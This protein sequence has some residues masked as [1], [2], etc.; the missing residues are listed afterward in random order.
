MTN[1]ED[2]RKPYLD[3]FFPG[4]IHSRYT[5]HL[6]LPLFVLWVAT[7]NH[8][9]HAPPA[10]N[11]TVLADSLYTRTNLHH[12]LFPQPKSR[13]S[14]CVVMCSVVFKC[15]T[16]WRLSHCTQ[17]FDTSL[18]IYHCSYSKTT[19]SRLGPEL[20]TNPKL[21]VSISNTALG[22]VVR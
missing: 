19:K 14:S 3:A 9:H 8:P 5:C 21:F 10:D 4:K 16:V 17:R 11:L 20:Q 7:A 6:T 2:V 22:K 1:T 13:Y 18:K 12:D 15:P